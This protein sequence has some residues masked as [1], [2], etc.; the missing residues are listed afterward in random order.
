[1]ITFAAALSWGSGLSRRMP[2]PHTF[3]EVELDIFDND[4]EQDAMIEHVEID[5]RVIQQLIKERLLPAL[6]G[7]P[8]GY[9]IMCMLTLTVLLMKP[10]CNVEELKRAVQAAS[11]TIVLALSTPSTTTVN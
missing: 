3:L 5:G 8:T 9:A 10:D 4:P 11:E 1:M 6:E 2:G 7:T